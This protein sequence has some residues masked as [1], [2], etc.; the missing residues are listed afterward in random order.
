M[1][2]HAAGLGKTYGEGA[3]A[4]S[5]AELKLKNGAFVSIVA[6]HANLDELV[7]AQVDVDLV[8]DRGCEPVL[9]DGDDGVKMMRLGAECAALA[10]C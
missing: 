6:E 1:T 3:I 8:Q 10:G 2:L 5:H 4:V 9:A 7:R